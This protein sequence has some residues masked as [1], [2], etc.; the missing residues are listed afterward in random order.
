MVMKTY[1]WQITAAA[2]LVLGAVITARVFW[3]R[4]PE[5][6]ITQ[7]PARANQQHTQQNRP[8]PSAEELYQTA[9]LHKEP[10]DSAQR[11]FRLVIA[12]CRQILEEPEI[13]STQIVS[14]GVRDTIYEKRI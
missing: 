1:W 3:P 9:L 5:S 14:G 8:R 12:Y 6:S 10:A 4:P 11:D 2:V 13:P 7:S